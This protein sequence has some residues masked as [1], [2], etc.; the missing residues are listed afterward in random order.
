M[1]DDV[2][3]WHHRLAQQLS[4]ANPAFY[5]ILW[6]LFQESENIPVD[7]KLMNEEKLSRYQRKET[8]GNLSRIFRVW[9]NYVSGTTSCSFLQMKFDMFYSPEIII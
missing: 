5:N 7:S 1:S 6:V 2:E 8:A 3:G 9:D 4:E